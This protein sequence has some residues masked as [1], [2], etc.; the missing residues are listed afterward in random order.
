MYG[1]S[2]W[3]PCA[4]V[5]C[6]LPP[7]ADANDKKTELWALKPVVRP[8]VSARWSMSSNPID[9]FIAEGYEAGGLKPVG[10]A[11]KRT[12]L[13]RVSLDDATSARSGS[14]SSPTRPTP[15]AA[16]STASAPS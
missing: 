2:R 3:I 11:D 15:G 7:Y 16:W 9:A 13:R 1:P 12:L 6:L 4:F 14:S 5:L 8:E 10:Q